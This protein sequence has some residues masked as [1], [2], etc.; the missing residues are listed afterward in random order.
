MKTHRNNISDAQI[1]ALYN[2]GWSIND[3]VVHHKTS[4]K[5]VRAVL[6][7][8]GVNTAGYRAISSYL[9]EC[10]LAMVATGISVRQLESII[11]Y[12]S[13]LIRQVLRNENKT[14]TYLRDNNNAI[15]A[16]HVIPAPIWL[17]FVELYISGKVGFM[18]CAEQCQF[19]LQNCVE[20]V[21]R[22]SENEINQHKVNLYSEIALY[23]ATGLSA[24]AVSK[25]LGVSPSI[26]K[27]IFLK[28]S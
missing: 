19:S 10:V 15:V 3:I 12:S 24:A 27:K 8:N 28:P 16:K 20:A 2:E 25:K 11:D 6:Q 7:N 17:Q 21:L 13:H 18:K 26:V 9:K 22:L 1:L 4:I 14:A 5:R 23:K